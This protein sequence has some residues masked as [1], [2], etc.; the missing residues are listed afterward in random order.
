MSLRAK[1]E[2]AKQFPRCGF[3]GRLL[4]GA[5]LPALL[6]V[7][8]LE[9]F[10][11]RHYQADLEQ[12]FQERGRAVARQLG[13]AAEFALFSGS[14][15][16]LRVLADAARRSDPLIVSVSVLDRAGQALEHSGAPPRPLAPLTDRLQ[17]HNT[18]ALTTVVAPIQQ[19]T[20]PVDAEAGDWSRPPPPR[21]PVLLGYIVVE[22]S[23]AG[24][25][26]RQREML[27]ITLA[28]M[29]GGLLL[30]S[31]LSLKI[32]AGVSRPIAH[33][34]EV[35]AQIGRGEFAARVAHDPAGVLAPLETGINDMAEKIALAQQ[36]LQ[37]QVA[38][39]TEELRRQKDAAEVMAHT[40]S[41]TGLANRRAFDEAAQRE[42]QRAL[43]YGTPLALVMTDL[44]LFKAVNDTHGH[45]AGD[46]ALVNFARILAA[47]VR[48][49]DLV[50]R[51]GG[52]EFAILMP[53]TGLEEALLAAERMRSAV[54]DATTQLAGGSSCCCTAS[55]G[56][57]ALVAQEPTLDD[58]LGR[59]DAALY[60][61]KERGRNRVES[62]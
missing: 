22:I 5:V 46:R 25:A 9:T 59:A 42:I 49:I 51:W 4:L 31:W 26:S 20:L 48:G 44:D 53:G 41:L 61:A 33:I 2:R 43:R 55:F 30:A 11:L 37:Q 19:G 35:V 24:L 32:A 39:A 36:D 29:L 8:L 17:V 12:A 47:S 62:G 28:I 38:I 15:T 21:Q 16:S 7:S 14:D 54:A 6:M 57:A 27:Q 1:S 40:D 52:E 18:D 13:P 45:H 10:F 56:V 58:L 34:N 3:R 23:R 50:G 60:R